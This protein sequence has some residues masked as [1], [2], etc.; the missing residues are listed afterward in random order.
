MEL[1]RITKGLMFAFVV[2]VSLNSCFMDHKEFYFI[3]NSSDD[4]LMLYIDTLDTLDNCL[5]W[6][7]E[8][9]D[10]TH[11]LFRDYNK[12][13]RIHG[14][15]YVLNTWFRTL[16]QTVSTPGFTIKR[17]PY[18]LYAVKWSVITHYT[19]DE[20]RAKKLYDRRI[21]TKEDFKDHVYEYK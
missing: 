5:Y 20:I 19:L 18:Y 6:D 11:F 21:V 4:T 17:K 7:I 3:K 15:T 12:E 16:P 8:K 1:K 2:I 10:T 13:I 14:K 9:E